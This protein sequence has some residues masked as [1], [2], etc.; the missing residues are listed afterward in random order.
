MQTAGKSHSPRGVLGCLRRLMNFPF[1]AML[2]LLL[3]SSPTPASSLSFLVL[4]KMKKT[5]HRYN[6]CQGALETPTVGYKAEVI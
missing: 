2:S 1:S 6:K 4:G 3:S 5:L